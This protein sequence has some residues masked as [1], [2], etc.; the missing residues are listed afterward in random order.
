[1]Y[2]SL[3]LPI[4]ARGTLELRSKKVFVP[5]GSAHPLARGPRADRASAVVAQVGDDFD[6]NLAWNDYAMGR[7]PAAPVELRDWDAELNEYVRRAHSLGKIDWDVSWRKEL[8]RRPR[9]HPFFWKTG[10]RWDDEWIRDRKRV[11]WERL[12]RMIEADRPR[13]KFPDGREPL[14]GVERFIAEVEE[15]ATA[16]RHAEDMWWQT[17]LDFYRVA[18]GGFAIAIIL[19]AVCGGF[20]QRGLPGRRFLI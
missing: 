18:A 17:V 10:V 9:L 2:C 3:F 19:I 12:Q 11:R 16:H 5:H 15:T 20:A 6:W 7:D 13:R 8:V 14:R 1:M 4:L